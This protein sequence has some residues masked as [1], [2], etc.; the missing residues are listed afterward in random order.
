MPRIGTASDRNGLGSRQSVAFPRE[1]LSTCRDATPSVAHAWS[2]E[3]GS[4]GLQSALDR[5]AA[6]HAVVQEA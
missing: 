4:F 2:S 5:A 6:A 3:F 1:T